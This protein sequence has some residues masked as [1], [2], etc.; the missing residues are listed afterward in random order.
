VRQPDGSLAMVEKVI[1][2]PLGIPD[3]PEEKQATAVE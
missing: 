2:L 1:E 3:P